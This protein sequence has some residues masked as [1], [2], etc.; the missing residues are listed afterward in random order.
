MQKDCRTWVRTCIQCQRFKTTKHNHTPTCNF[1]EP[2][3]RFQHIH[4]DI[5]GPLSPSRGYK[6]CLTCT[7][8]FTRW[9]EAILVT[10]I[11]AEIIAKQLFENW[12]AR[13][14]GTNNHGSRETIRNRLI[15][16]ANSTYGPDT[17]GQ[18]H[19]IRKQMEW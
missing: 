10:S 12:I 4:I 2:S 11:S 9:S 15:S 7:D 6:Y 18:R 16:E 3:R 13:C 17:G 19:T 1:K 8:R 5:I 14:S